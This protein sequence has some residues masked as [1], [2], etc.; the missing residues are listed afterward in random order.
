MHPDLLLQFGD[1]AAEPLLRDVQ[2]R[3]R[4]REMQLIGEGHK[5]PQPAGM[6]VHIV[7]ARPRAGV[8]Q[9]VAADAPNEC[10]VAPGA[11]D[12][13]TRSLPA[14]AATCADERGSPEPP[15]VRDGPG[16][17]EPGPATL[18]GTVAPPSAQAGAEYLGEFGAFDVVLEPE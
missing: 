12:R 18:P 5:V 1:A 4:V 6:D 11:G 8:P 15:A 7:K 3:G 2:G 14:P 10:G 17:G 9:R 13:P 16:A